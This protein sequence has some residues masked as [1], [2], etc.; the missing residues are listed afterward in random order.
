MDKK[1]VSSTDK[2]YLDKAESLL[3]SEISI[4]LSMDMGEINDKVSAMFQEI[5]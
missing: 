5:L 3:Y 1:K 2:K 4:S